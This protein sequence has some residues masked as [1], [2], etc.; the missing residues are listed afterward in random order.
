MGFLNLLWDTTTIVLLAILRFYLPVGITG[1]FIFIGFK[2]RNIYLLV[3]P[4]F[5]FIIYFAILLAHTD[6]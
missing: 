2:K 4:S 3:V 1:Y 5:I 6:V